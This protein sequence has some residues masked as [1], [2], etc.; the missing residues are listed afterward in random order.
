MRNKITKIFENLKYLKDQEVIFWSKR[1]GHW[2]VGQI[3][4][5]LRN[6]FGSTSFFNWTNIWISK[7]LFLLDQKVTHQFL[8]CSNCSN[9]LVIFPNLFLMLYQFFFQKH[10]IMLAAN[11][12][13]VHWSRPCKF[14]MAERFTAKSLNNIWCDTNVLCK[15]QMDAGA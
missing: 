9:S 8:E 14:S 10:W 5:Q 15:C 2:L 11:F 12:N 1:T 3:F 6:Q 7:N 4:D 13:L